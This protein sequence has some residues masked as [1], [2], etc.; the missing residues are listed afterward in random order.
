MIQLEFDHPDHASKAEKSWKEIAGAL[1]RILGYNVELRITLAHDDSNKKLKKPCLSLF[2]CSRRVH[3][4][5]Q[6]SAESGSNASEISS[7]TPTTV[8]TRDKYVETCSSECG[9]RI[10][11]TCCHGKELFKT[12]RSSDGNALS[13]E[14]GAPDGVVAQENPLGSKPRYAPHS[15][16]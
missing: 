6:L 4:R 16:G 2:N 7:S 3:L 10:S 11:C 14:A 12:I 8:R 15:C 1:Q 5:S 13:I 9:S